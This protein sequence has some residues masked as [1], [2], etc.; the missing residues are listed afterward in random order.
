MDAEFRGIE[1][2]LQSQQFRI[3]NS[4]LPLKDFK[5]GQIVIYSCGTVNAL[6]WRRDE[7]VYSIKG[8]CITV[9]R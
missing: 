8:S 3:V 2:D 6:M 4:T 1:N 5:N 9:W 7:D